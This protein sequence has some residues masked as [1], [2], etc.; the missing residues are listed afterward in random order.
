MPTY[1]VTGRSLSFSDSLTYNT[2]AD[3]IERMIRESKSKRVGER[4]KECVLK[5]E[6]PVFL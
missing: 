1:V 5:S 3:S 6:A 2:V 4:E